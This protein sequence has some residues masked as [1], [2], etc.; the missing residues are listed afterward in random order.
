MGWLYG[1][2]SKMLTSYA[3]ALTAFLVNAVPRYVDMPAWITLLLWVLPGV[4]MGVAAAQL[5]KSYRQKYNALK[6]HRPMAS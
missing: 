3:A 6:N 5:V 1:H 4:G 2:I